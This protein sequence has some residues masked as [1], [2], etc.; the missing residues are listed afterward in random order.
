[1][2]QGQT[3]P[4]EHIDPLLQLHWKLTHKISNHD[5]ET[6]YHVTI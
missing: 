1:M 6:L 2:D 5:I 4:L 3:I